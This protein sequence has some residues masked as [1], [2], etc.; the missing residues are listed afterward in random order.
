MR[1]HYPMPVAP[2][3]ALL[4]G[5]AFLTQAATCNSNIRAR[6]DHV[7]SRIGYGPDAWSRNRI[8][9]LGINGDI[10]EQLQPST[11][12]DSALDAEIASLYPVTTMT[13][14][15]SRQTYHE[16]T[17]NPETGPYA[18]VRDGSRAKI[19]RAVKSKKQLE[20]VLV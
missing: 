17:G 18:P 15:Q 10:E 13:Y 3:I 11:L 4:V 9:E 2:R 1:P 7:L 6:Q 19:L 8:N 12:D 16:Y 5:L 20:Q 14:V